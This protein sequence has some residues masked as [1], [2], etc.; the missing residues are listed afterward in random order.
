VTADLEPVSVESRLEWFREH[1][2]QRPLWIVENSKREIV[3]WVSFQD[4]YG[5]PAYRHT[6]EI[7][8]YLH[9]EHRGKGY[10]REILLHCISMCP[11]L[12]LHTLLGYIFEHN[13]RSIRLFSSAGFETWARLPNIALMDDTERSLII[14]G[15]R[16]S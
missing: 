8:I 16:I 5:R 9:P 11:S 1:H 13:E 12:S 4:F 2:K 7:S 15:K 14:M 10:G 3:G 6:A